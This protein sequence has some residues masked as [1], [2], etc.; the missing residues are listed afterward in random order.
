MQVTKLIC[1]IKN[2]VKVIISV[3]KNVKQSIIGFSFKL[4]FLIY[5]ISNQNS[6]SYKRTALEISPIF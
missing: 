3:L 2:I 1:K 4:M 5:Q 6:F